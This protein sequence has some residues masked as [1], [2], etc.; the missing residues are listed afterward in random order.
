MD[1]YGRNPGDPKYK[2]PNLHEEDWIHHQQ[3]KQ[4]WAKKRPGNSVAHVDQFRDD[5]VYDKIME[6]QLAKGARA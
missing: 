1:E 6:E 2:D 3:A 4:E 5:D